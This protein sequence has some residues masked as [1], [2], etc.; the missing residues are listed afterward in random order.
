MIKKVKKGSLI[1]TDK[2]RSYGGLVIYGFRD[3]R[4]DKSIRRKNFRVSVLIPC[5][6]FLKHQKVP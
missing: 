5:L 1:Y 2:F 3:E 4:Q 6:L